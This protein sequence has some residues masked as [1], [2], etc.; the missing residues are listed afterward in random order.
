MTE[1][2][3]G[4]EFLVRPNDK[5]EDVVD[6]ADGDDELEASRPACAL[7]V[8]RRA[9]VTSRLRDGSAT[10]FSLYFCLCGKSLPLV[11]LMLLPAIEPSS[12]NIVLVPVNIFFPREQVM[13]RVMSEDR[14]GELVV[15][16]CVRFCLY[17][18]CVVVK[19]FYV[20]LCR[21]L[22]LVV[23]CVYR[24]GFEASDEHRDFSL[25]NEILRPI[26][27]THKPTSMR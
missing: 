14:A 3:I 22:A 23:I 7:V 17:F 26:V 9:V 25:R 12:A 4:V 6:D 15:E 5:E 1:D 16:I 24:F 10:V 20:H 13:G 8:S 2:E 21:G 19:G 27:I 11:C 18:R